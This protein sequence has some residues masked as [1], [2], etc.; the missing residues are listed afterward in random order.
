MEEYD[1]NRNNSMV[2]VRLTSIGD[3]TDCSNKKKENNGE[4]EK[5]ILFSS[6]LNCN[7]Q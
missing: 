5:K 2:K 1:N 6:C 7:I 3:F 4:K